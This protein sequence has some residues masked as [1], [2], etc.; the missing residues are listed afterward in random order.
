MEW[1]FSEMCGIKVSGE[2]EFTIAP[3]V[4]GK[5]IDIVIFSGIRYRL[6]RAIPTSKH[7]LSMAIA[8][9][10]AQ[11]GCRVIDICRMKPYESIDGLH[12]NAG[13]MRQIAE[14]ALAEITRG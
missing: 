13:G 10:A 5:Q 7:C 14:A 3:K 8:K 6:S 12:P 1:V 9:S 4:G 11:N 2:N